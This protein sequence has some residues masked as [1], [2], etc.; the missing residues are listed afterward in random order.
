MYFVHL[1][2]SL[3]CG[4]GLGAVV[5]SNVRELTDQDFQTTVQ[6]NNIVL[7]TFFSQTCPHCVAFLPELEK[8]ASM[9]RSSRSS[10]LVAKVNC[11]EGGRTTCSQANAKTVPTVRI[12]RNGQ[13]SSDFLGQRNAESVV[14]FVNAAN[15]YGFSQDYNYNT[16]NQ[17]VNSNN[18]GNQGNV[19][20]VNNAWQP[21]Y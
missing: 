17:V 16:N 1:V 13:P 6:N 2:F 19:N 12:Y 7:V 5:P 15:N 14:S 4:L 9:L 20:P 8:A 18:Y 3:L 10:V 21:H 11:G